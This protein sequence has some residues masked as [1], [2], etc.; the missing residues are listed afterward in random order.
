[1]EKVSHEEVL[2]AANVAGPKMV[3]LVY[4]MLPQL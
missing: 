3:Q 4:D 2:M 1:V